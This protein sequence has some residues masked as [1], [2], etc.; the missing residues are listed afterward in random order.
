[1]KVC[2]LCEKQFP[3]GDTCP[4]DGTPLSDAPASLDPL[5]GTVLKDTYRVEQRVGAGGMGAVYRGTQLPLGRPVAIKVLLPDLQASEVF[6]KRFFLEAKVLSQLSHPHVVSLIDFGSTPEGLLFMVL[7]FLHGAALEDLVPRGGL[8]TSSVVRLMDQVCA[9]VGAAHHVRLLHRDLKPSN[10]FVTRQSDG[11]EILKVLDFGIARPMEGT[12]TR[13]T[14]TGRFMGTPGFISPEQVIGEK[15][16]DER[17]DI[18]AL[19][20]VLYF[21]LTGRK[22]YEGVT[23]V[24]IF[25]QQ[26]NLVETPLEFTPGS[27]A[28]AFQGVVRRAVAVRPEDR[29]QTVAELARAVRAAAGVPAGVP[30]EP[31]GLVTPARVPAGGPAGRRAKVRATALAVAALVA[32]VAAAWWLR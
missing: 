18:W 15:E 23:A 21:L 8:P 2:P 14:A 27:P 19:G 10:L 13:L 17:S 9:G 7:E 11:S 20:A 30:T 25:E 22:V 6:V 32:A 26:A 29:Y 28:A 12:S 16:A 24:D 31:G 3:D 1:M 5:P 4:H